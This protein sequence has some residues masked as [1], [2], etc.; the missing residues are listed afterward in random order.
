MTSDVVRRAVVQQRGLY[1]GA[2]HTAYY[3]DGGHAGHQR[4][5]RDSSPV[6]SDFMLTFTLRRLC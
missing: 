1:G 2:G 4:R 6:R 5:R 3:G